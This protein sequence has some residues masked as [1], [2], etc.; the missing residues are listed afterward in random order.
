MSKTRGVHRQYDM[1]GR[2]GTRLGP[3]RPKV[4]PVAPTRLAG[5]VGPD[6]FP[7]TI[8]TTSQTKLV[9]GVS[10]VRKV[11]ERLNMATRPSCMAERPDKWASHVQSL[12][13]ALPYSSYKYPHAPPGIE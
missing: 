2:C 10:N 13:R 12:A 9:R 7:K 6:A 8:F 11:M 1:E 5:P 3:S 4:G